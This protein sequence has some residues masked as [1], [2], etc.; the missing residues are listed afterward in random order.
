MEIEEKKAEPL[1]PV[2]IGSVL[3]GSC[4][5][6]SQGKFP[7]MACALIGSIGA[8][9]FY[10]YQ[11]GRP[12]RFDR[13]AALG[14]GVGVAGAIFSFSLLGFIG[15]LGWKPARDL[16]ELSH[17]YENIGLSNSE[18][19]LVYNI[20]VGDPTFNSVG[21]GLFVMVALIGAVC[22][23]LT[24]LAMGGWKLRGS[25]VREKLHE[26]GILYRQGEDVPLPAK[27]KAGF[28]L[29]FFAFVALCLVVVVY[30]VSFILYELEQA[31]GWFSIAFFFIS[32]ASFYGALL[33]GAAA[34]LGYTATV[35]HFPLEE[36]YM[37]ARARA[38]I[39][40]VISFS[41]VYM[42]IASF[43]R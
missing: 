19:S 43:F 37:P 4:Y 36:K 39:M 9:W 12:I 32:F 10:K 41:L 40:A 5:L 21:V 13:G 33:F 3:V 2:G 42:F 30:N 11:L 6:L 24:S 1:W 14:G 20:Y 16:S 7:I 27:A 29:S 26:H 8:V 34:F 25:Y 15:M 35:F 28:R 22:G 31:V 17:T 38:A 23:G 18:I